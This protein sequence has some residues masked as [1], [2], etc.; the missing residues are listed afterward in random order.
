MKPAESP[1][2]VLSLNLNKDQSVWDAFLD[3][4]FG[5]RQAVRE[6]RDLNLVVEL[7]SPASNSVVALAVLCTVFPK[8]DLE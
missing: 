8:L 3:L 7:K 6:L 5:G 2:S 4:I 1:H